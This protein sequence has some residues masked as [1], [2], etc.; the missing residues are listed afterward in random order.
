MVSYLE[1]NDRISLVQFNGTG[2]RLTPLISINH[3]SN[4]NLI[5]QKIKNLEA[6]GGTNICNGLEIA[7]EI[8][9]QRWYKNQISS[10]FLFS[11]GL[12]EKALQK[13]K[14]LVDKYIT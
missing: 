4:F 8:F 7:F 12:D 13:T 1:F 3:S 14:L 6:K 5:S 11:D 9:D 2:E 10:I